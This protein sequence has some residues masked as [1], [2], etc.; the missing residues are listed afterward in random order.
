MS[1]KITLLPF[2]KKK[3]KLKKYGS[4]EGQVKNVVVIINKS[5]FKMFFS[6]IIQV[7]C[8]YFFPSVKT[9]YS[10]SFFFLIQ[11]KINNDV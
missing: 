2:R 9:C 11:E 3:K 6:K 8:I 4:P 10:F 1:V 5:D 7:F